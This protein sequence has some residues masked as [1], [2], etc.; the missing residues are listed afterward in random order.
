MKVNITDFHKCTYCNKPVESKYWYCE[1]CQDYYNNKYQ[2][3][4]YQG[5]WHL[6]DKEVVD[7]YLKKTPDREE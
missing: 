1:S 7:K 6:E 3:Y 4:K 5:E 2:D